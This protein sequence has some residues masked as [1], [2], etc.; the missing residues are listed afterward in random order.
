MGPLSIDEQ[1]AQMLP[2]LEERARIAED[3]VLEDEETI[4]YIPDGFHENPPYYTVKPDGTKTAITKAEYKAGMRE[5]FTVKHTTNPTC[6]HRIV[7]GQEPRHR[8]CDSCWFTYFQ[9]HGEITKLADEIFQKHGHE[10]G[11]QIVAQI[12]GRV[13]LNNYLKFMSTVAQW[14]A[15]METAQQSA[16][17]TKE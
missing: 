11:G 3:K 9:V 17:D 4:R 16:P 2:V 6:G 7:V 13:F 1:V 8:N 12:K 14:K 5:Q 15:N 10:E